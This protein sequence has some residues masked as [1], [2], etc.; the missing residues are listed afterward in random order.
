LAG[1]SY[2]LLRAYSGYAILAVVLTIIESLAC[3]VV[4]GIK[5][6]TV[7]AAAE[8]LRSARMGRF[9]VRLIFERILGT[10]GDPA[11]DEK[12]RIAQG[13]EKIPLAQAEQRLTDAVSAILRVD[14]NAPN[15]PGWFRRVI[16]AQLLA[17]VKKFTLR[18]FRTENA[19][20]GGVDLVK[21]GDELENTVD[22]VLANQLQSKARWLTVFV[23]GGLVLA[24]VAQALGLRLLA[25][26]DLSLDMGPIGK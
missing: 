24:V 14:S 18:R 19:Q 5:R 21:I 9:G 15:R 25:G 7:I 4:V 6:A 8:G 13:I 11:T 10:G 1:A 26:M 17:G 23:F 3:G 22:D 12:C 2:Y 20:A 16:Q